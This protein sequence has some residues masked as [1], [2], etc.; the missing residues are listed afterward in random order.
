MKRDVQVSEVGGQAGLDGAGSPWWV[1]ISISGELGKTVINSRI[2]A[3]LAAE[4]ESE[5]PDLATQL[6]KA[7]ASLARRTT[8][9]EDPGM[10]ADEVSVDPEAIERA[11]QIL[12]LEPPA[13]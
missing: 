2:A 9:R 11:F 8:P 1:G 3:D 7:A 13:D 12:G 4:I 6:R 5:D 10:E